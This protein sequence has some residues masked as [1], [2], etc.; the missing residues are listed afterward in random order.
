MRRLRTRTLVTITA[1]F[2]KIHFNTCLVMNLQEG[3]E[4]RKFGANEI[5]GFMPNLTPCFPATDDQL[6]DM[7]LNVLTGI[8]Y[9]NKPI[10]Y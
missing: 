8:N 1:Q 10:F 7:K 4:S 5:V 3:D 2:P 9:F 6:N